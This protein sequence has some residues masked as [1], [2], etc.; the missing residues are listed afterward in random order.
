MS[1]RCFILRRVYWRCRVSSWSCMLTG[2]KDG[3]LKSLSRRYRLLLGRWTERHSLLV[4]NWVGLILCS[5]NYWVLPYISLI[6]G[7]YWGRRRVSDG[8][9]TFILQWWSLKVLVHIWWTLS[10][11][12]DNMNSLSIP[13]KDSVN[14]PSKWARGQLQRRRPWRIPRFRFVWSHSHLQAIILTDPKNKK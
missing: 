1:G 14:I 10:P 11:W 3:M 2:R 6:F 5:L 9:A 7:R 12:I 4:V 8:S 13:H